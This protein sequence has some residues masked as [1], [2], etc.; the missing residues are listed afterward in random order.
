MAGPPRR[1]P[2]PA[3]P[4]TE[5]D[6]PSESRWLDTVGPDS[7]V[8]VPPQPRLFRA[9]VMAQRQT[10]W[11]GTVL[12][13]P[14][15]THRVFTLVALL[16]T[17]ATLAL[18]AFGEYT[19]SAR[20]AGW[21]Q[22]Q[23]GVVR[24]FSPRPGVVSSL[25]VSEGMRVSKG[26]PLLS[27]SDELQSAALG[28]TQAE[29]MRRLAERRDSLGDEL[30]QQRRM[31]KQQDQAF[32]A[33]LTGLRA[34]LAQIESEIALQRS[35]VAIA[36]RAEA[37][38]REQFQAGFIAELR[39]QQIESELLEQRARLGAM[40][41]SALVAA[42]EITGIEAERADLPLRQGRETAALTRS[43]SQL[44]QEHAEAEARR[45]IVVAAPQEGIVTAV[46]A[47]LGAR[48]DPAAP[49]L[50][51]V[52]QDAT[53][54]A[55]LYSP[56]RAVGFVRP[57]QRVLLR[58][59][60]YP[61]QRFGHYEGVVA[62]VSRTALSPAELPS[63]L[64]GVANPATASGGGGGAAEPV[65]RITVNLS[66]QAVMAY[67]APVRLQPGMALEAD[68]A[69]ER[70]RLYEWVLDPLYAVTGQRG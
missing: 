60:A 64:A 70:R 66:S 49:L 68:V 4:R 2:S 9:E 22:P 16:F 67:G 19:R 27:L 26:A 35:R 45:E 38:Y 23:Q 39:L 42:R 46:H 10:Q 55:H 24:V 43:L 6:G 50:V 8:D 69:L 58:Y 30:G 15:T 29:V 18:L 17:A 61:Y 12:L 20:I 62:S 54:E 5:R 7:V 51:L 11:L 37:L 65:Y 47:V 44:A 52:G 56:S 32:G 53:L 1:Q 57:G 13:A 59:Q 48:A 31:L 40:Q 14:R 34:E 36:S 33:R 3:R 28:A 63:I 21:L 41:R 25:H